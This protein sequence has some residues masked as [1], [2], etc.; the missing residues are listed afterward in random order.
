MRIFSDVFCN[1]KDFAKQLGSP[2]VHGVGLAWLVLFG[3]V[4]WVQEAA[5]DAKIAFHVRFLRIDGVDRG[6]LNSF[7]NSSIYR[8]FIKQCKNEMGCG[9]DFIKNWILWPIALIISIPIGYIVSLIVK[10]VGVILLHAIM[11]PDVIRRT[12]NSV[13][14]FNKAGAP[15][16]AT[17]AREHHVMIQ[18][19]APA[20]A[21]TG[22]LRDLHDYSHEGLPTALKF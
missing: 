22:F 7:N 1:A 10:I 12:V 13:R 18:H 5:D 9:S 21:A 17:D 14:T 19:R 15:F 20:L 3:A 2:A 11:T 16:E 8:V 6:H 4:D